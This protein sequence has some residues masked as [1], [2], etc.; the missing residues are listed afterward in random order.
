LTEIASSWQMHCTPANQYRLAT[1]MVQHVGDSLLSYD[2][3][4]ATNRAGLLSPLE[5]S[6]RVVVKGKVKQREKSLSAESFKR[7]TIRATRATARRTLLATGFRLRLTSTK[8][9]AA[10]SDRSRA[11][12][13]TGPTELSENGF[14]DV[15]A[16]MSARKKFD[17]QARPRKDDI[18][19]FYAS[20]LSLRTEPIAS[21]MERRQSKW[22]LPITSVNEDRYLRLLGIS[23]LER[24]TI[25]GLMGGR[26]QSTAALLGLTGEQQT[27]HAVVRL[28]VNPPAAVGVM[29]RRTA[30]WM[31]RP[32]PLGYAAVT[33]TRPFEVGRLQSNLSRCLVWQSAILRHQPESAAL[34]AGRQ[35]ACLPE[36]LRCGHRGAAALCT[37]SRL[38]G[39][40]AQTARDA[41][42][43]RR[44]RVG[45]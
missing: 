35:S 4:V 10:A 43:G 14:S 33:R 23:V 39:L 16:K 8:P 13:I 17:K 20:Y 9:D 40:R 29:Q 18:D 38:Q 44:G 36:F 3:L 41:R 7:F 19:D 37:L 6:C 27:L 24:N 1:M 25:E 22:A 31:L 15:Q 30:S 12:S 34:L 26:A 42:R 32:Y 21:F 2:E 28:A 11:S 5:L 45:G